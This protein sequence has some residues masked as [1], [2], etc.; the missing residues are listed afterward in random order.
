MTDRAP[1]P[2]S[3]TDGSLGSALPG[4]YQNPD[5]VDQQRWWTGVDW[6]DQT[7][8]AVRPAPAP[9]VNRAARNGRTVGFVAGGL[10][11]LMIALLPA[12][13]VSD[14][15]T[16]LL[17]LL[18]AVFLV[19]PLALIFGLVAI[20][21]SGAGLR[22]APV[23]GGRG[24]AVGGL[25]LGIISVLAPVALIAAAAPAFLSTGHS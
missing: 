25:T 14:M 6:A 21:V 23:R 9:G 8:A 4:W 13:N 2:P 10:T 15:S 17:L 7:R 18:V 1:L 24:V 5:D 11:L 19:G 16:G 12:T 3:P 20:V 22:R